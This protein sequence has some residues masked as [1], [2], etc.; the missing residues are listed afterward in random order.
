MKSSLPASA[1]ASSASFKSPVSI[2]LTT[3]A[4]T[5]PIAAE[6]NAN[7]VPVFAAA[8]KIKFTAVGVAAPAVKYDTATQIRITP[9]PIATFLMISYDLN[10]AGVVNGKKV[11]QRVL[12]RKK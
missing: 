4:D 3:P 7:A 2:P 10:A 6:D 1:A 9:V 8:V 12:I 11:Y 5:P